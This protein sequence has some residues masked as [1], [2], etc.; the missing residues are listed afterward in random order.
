MTPDEIE[1]ALREL[2]AAQASEIA[3]RVVGPLYGDRQALPNRRT[4][5]IQKAAIDAQSIYV[6]TGEY[7]DGRL[8]EVFV[9]A[10]QS[11]QVD[12]EG[13]LGCFAAAVSMGLQYG[14]PLSAFV[15]AFTFT[16]FNPQGMVN[17]HPDIRLATSPIDYLF[18]TLA[19]HYLDR[20][21]LAHNDEG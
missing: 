9:R 5:L 8:G 21:D 1:S 7:K 16:K 6:H 10:K 12:A 14:V 2:P 11:S 18:R 19:I 17:G 4:G 13:V 20:A 3:R 15:D